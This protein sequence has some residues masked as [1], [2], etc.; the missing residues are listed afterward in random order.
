M[1]LPITHIK[2]LLKQLFSKRNTLLFILIFLTIS[3]NKEKLDNE[4]KTAI[5]TELS[6]FEA[7]DLP[8]DF[9]SAL[10]E[11]DIMIFG[12]MHYTQQQQ[13]FISTILPIIH[14][15]GYRIILEEY[16]HCWSWIVEDYVA[17]ERDELPEYILFFQ[18]TT[19]TAIRAFNETIVGDQKIRLAYMD[20]NHWTTNFPTAIEE[21]EAEIGIQPFFDNVRNATVDDGNYLT[22][23]VNIEGMLLTEAEDFKTT[24]GEKWYQRILD[25][26]TVEISSSAYRTERDHQHREM[27]MLGNI[28]NF[29]SVHENEK[30]LINT[31]RR[32]GLKSRYPGESFDR[33]GKLLHDT[34]D[35]T[36]SIAFVGMSGEQKKTFDSQATDTFD[37]PGSSDSN[38]AIQ[39]IDDTAGGQMSYL[40]LQN[41]VFRNKDVK[42]SFSPGNTMQEPIGKFYDG[43]L[44]YP[45]VT[46][47]ESMGKYDWQQ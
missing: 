13:D 9:T 39:L 29:L 43:I 8:I 40:P 22:I 5:Q 3:C 41:E 27:T 12:E 36:F 18:E 16:P 21:V 32:H 28:N 47:L 46:I 37:L 42:I 26:V 17:G 15:N 20:V 35:K 6:I 44:T 25:M 2:S 45:S 23:L 30:A 7:G 31:G 34:N 10:A 4:V 33:I 11:N 19:A 24:W 14:N 1:T 38:D